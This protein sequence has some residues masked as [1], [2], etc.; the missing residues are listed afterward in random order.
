MVAA[1]IEKNTGWQAELKLGFKSQGMRTVLFRREHYGP[2]AVQKPFYPEGS[3]CHV[4]LLHPP[5]G[6]VGGDQLTIQ[7]TVEKDAHALVT[8]PASG[9]FYRSAGKTAFQKQ[10]LR[11]K[12]NGI[13]EWMPQ[14]TILFSGCNVELSTRVDLQTDSTFIGWEILC[15]GRPA[16]GE[17]FEKGFCRQRFEIWR[18]NQPVLIERSL[19]EG[20][21]KVLQE[22]WG[23][24]GYP[25]LGTMVV[26]SADKDVLESARSSVLED[27]ND[28]FSATLIDNVLVCRYLGRQGESARHCFIK[29]WKAIRPQV[30]G[31]EACLPRI[32]NT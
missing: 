19:L 11:V 7:T 21:S 27:G 9:K 18:E 15:L 1:L 14:D 28:L 13:L 32:W 23:L 16:S 2:L 8:T 31:M 29:V 5:G 6:V 25:V 22:A 3:P 12:Q 10:Q 17:R 26:T 30:L 24:A 20:N 4:Y